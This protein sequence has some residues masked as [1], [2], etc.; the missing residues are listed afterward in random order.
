[1]F[2]EEPEGDPHGE[3]AKE[4]HD[5]QAERDRLRAAIDGPIR[6]IAYDVKQGGILGDM[7]LEQI[8]KALNS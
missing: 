3:C 1:M 8:E 2:D 5:L 4:I 7:L 6:R